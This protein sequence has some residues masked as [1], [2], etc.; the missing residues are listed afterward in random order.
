M[1]RRD[2]VVVLGALFLAIGISAVLFVGT[3]ATEPSV[4]NSVPAARPRIFF[5]Q[6]QTPPP[7][8]RT[9]ADVQQQVGPLAA[10]VP[11]QRGVSD[12][13]REAAGFLLVLIVTATTLTIAHT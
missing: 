9:V 7:A 8:T 6:R 3:M 1:N 4:T 5:D 2:A 12:S 10:V 11:L 13:A